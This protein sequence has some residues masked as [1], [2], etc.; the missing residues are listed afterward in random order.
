[1]LLSRLCSLFLSLELILPEIHDFAD[2]DFPVDC[3]LNKI[4]TSFLRSRKRVALI[5]GAVVL[6]MLV[7][8]LNVAGDYSLIN[9]RSLFSG[10]ASYRTADVTSPMSVDDASEGLYRPVTR[11]TK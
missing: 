9:A 7:D 4:E 1:L 3:N 6:P 10:R 2:R 11:L 5:G 8:E